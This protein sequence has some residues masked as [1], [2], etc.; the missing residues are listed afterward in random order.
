MPVMVPEMTTIFLAEPVRAV[1]SASSV[2][3]VVTLP[4]EPPV[5]L[6]MTVISYRYV[7]NDLD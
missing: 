7:I 2:V 6:V 3:T 4:P 5:V 1:V